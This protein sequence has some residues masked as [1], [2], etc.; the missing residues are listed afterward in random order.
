MS[1]ENGAM[2]FK[3]LRLTQHVDNIVSSGVIWHLADID[4]VWVFRI[5]NIFMNVHCIW[6]RSVWKNTSWTSSP[7]KIGLI[8]YDRKV[9]KNFDSFKCS[10][11]YQS[12]TLSMLAAWIP[13]PN[14]PWRRPLLGDLDLLCFQID[15]H[16]A[17]LW[18][19][20]GFEASR[21][22]VPNFS[23][24]RSF[25]CHTFSDIPARNPFLEM[26]CFLLFT[27]ELLK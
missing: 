17:M 2:K 5:V 20:W 14:R 23:V 26:I 11:T 1:G 25:C 13:G 15:R 21:E 24:P 8:A 22:N 4:I 6:P 12:W 27:F 18:L 19:H 3:A 9:Y 16:T 7:G 10:T